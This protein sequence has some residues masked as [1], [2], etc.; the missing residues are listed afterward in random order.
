MLTGTVFFICNNQLSNHAKASHM[1]TPRRSKTDR[2][3][4][5]DRLYFP[6]PVFTGERSFVYGDVV[7]SHIVIPVV[8]APEHLVIRR[9]RPRSHQDHI[10]L[11]QI[12][13]REIEN[14]KA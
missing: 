14:L 10:D 4:V 13:I 1:K 5:P 2:K 7:I 11:K 8:D 9:C 12:L 6:F 3:G